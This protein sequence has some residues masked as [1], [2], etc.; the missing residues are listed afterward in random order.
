MLL[1]A[2]IFFEIIVCFSKLQYLLVAFV[3]ELVKFGSALFHYGKY[4]Q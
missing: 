3:P 4:S 2:A 1:L